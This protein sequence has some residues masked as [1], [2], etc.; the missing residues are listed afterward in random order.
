MDGRLEYREGLFVGYR[1]YDRDGRRPRYPFGHGLGY[2]DWT[3][4]SV[5]A[6]VTIPAGADL[7]AL[8]SVRNT[9][10]RP[11]REVVQ[12]YLSKQDSAVE[13]PVRWLAGFTAVHAEPGQTVHAEVTLPARAFQHWEP[14]VGWTTE[15][16]PYR[17]HA[18]RS[19]ASLPIS[20]PVTVTPA[21]PVRGAAAS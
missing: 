2:T 16:G 19:A 3:Y 9:G 18:G 6:P 13:R 5:S 4:Q 11:G 8:V 7:T 17:L 14:A 21:V 1:G 15:P 12:V 10:R 20:I